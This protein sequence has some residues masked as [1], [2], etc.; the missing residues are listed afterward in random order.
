MNFKKLPGKNELKVVDWKSSSTGKQ[1]LAGLLKDLN[2][3]A[4]AHDQELQRLQN[5]SK[6]KL[7]MLE[8]MVKLAE[9]G[10]ADE[11]V[12][13]TMLE[14]A[15]TVSAEISSLGEA[16]I[17]VGTD[18]TNACI[19]FREVNSFQDDVPVPKAFAE[20]LSKMR[21]EHSNKTKMASTRQVKINE[22]YIKR[23]ET[24]A[25]Q[26]AVFADAAITVEKARL[27]CGK[28]MESLRKN[29]SDAEFEQGRL[30]K[31][32]NLVAKWVDTKPSNWQTMA[33]N[34]C[35][36]IEKNLKML[37]SHVSTAKTQLEG[38][39]KIWNALPPKDQRKK[40]PLVECGTVLENLKKICNEYK[41]AH[42]KTKESVAKAKI[43]GLVE[44]HDFSW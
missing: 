23:A 19:N 2:D 6:D 24:L 3:G 35:V 20:I 25:A 11:K 15:K 8:G 14:K 39:K 28:L 44:P 7:T 33:T 36:D 22:D 12:A 41:S 43:K 16:A 10:E 9:T 18:F 42:L 32:L 26:I 37:K 34:T 30:V 4:T 27:E 13:K 31:N 1:F 40:S 29:A 5:L 17:K 21:T 38:V